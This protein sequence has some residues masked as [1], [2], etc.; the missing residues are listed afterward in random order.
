MGCCV[1]GTDYGHVGVVVVLRFAG[2][3]LRYDA[4]PSVHPTL[5]PYYAFRSTLLYTLHPTPYTLHPTP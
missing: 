3:E 5:A 2:A 1:L 4:T